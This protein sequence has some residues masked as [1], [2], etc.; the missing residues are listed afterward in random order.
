MRSRRPHFAF[1]KHNNSF[2]ATVS[3][4]RGT[5]MYYVITYRGGG[6]FSVKD[7]YNNDKKMMEITGFEAARNCV[8]PKNIDSRKRVFS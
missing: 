2:I 1:F 7:N 6:R 8:Q 4:T 5:S 3:Y